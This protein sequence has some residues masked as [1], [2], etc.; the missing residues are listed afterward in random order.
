MTSFSQSN[1]GRR[2]FTRYTSTPYHSRNAFMQ[3]GFCSADTMSC[4]STS[5]IDGRGQSCDN[6]ARKDAMHLISAG[7]NE[8]IRNDIVRGSFIIPG[9]M[10]PS[11]VLQRSNPYHNLFSLHALDGANRGNIYSVDRPSPNYRPSISHEWH[12]PAVA[13][14]LQSTSQYL[15]LNGSGNFVARTQ[16]RQHTTRCFEEVDVTV[17]TRRSALRSTND[18]IVANMLDEMISKVERRNLGI[19][20]EWKNNHRINNLCLK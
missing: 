3:H 17:P 20:C 1:C 16:P 18:F 12:T 19:D 10:S 2:A 7:R 13:G 9:S 6:T 15:N 5:A 4:I 14:M 8:I 11:S